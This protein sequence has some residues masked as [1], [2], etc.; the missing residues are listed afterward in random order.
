MLLSTF[1]F[2][3]I[4]LFFV[5]AFFT[6]TII[7]SF[8]NVY[9]YR[10]HTG[11]SLSGSSHCMSC[12]NNL[13]WYELVPLLSWIMLRG[14]CSSC[15]CNITPRYFLVELLTGVLFGLTLLI[16]L[17]VAEIIIMWYILST[18]VAITV[19][20]LYH[21]IIPDRLTAYLTG[22]SI[23]LFL[24]QNLF[25]NN[26][27]DNALPT[28]A[29]AALGSLFFYILWFVSR[30]RWLGFGDVKLALPLG[31]LVGPGLVFS[32]VVLAFWV[33]AGISILLIIANNFFGGKN[34]LHIKSKALTMKSEVPFA[35]FLIA[36]SL[37]IIFTN[38]NV[39]DL[40][41]FT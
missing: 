33:G 8:L 26:S 7:G 4:E 9:I 10:F 3:P 21:F 28:L 34:R 15:G 38:F 16:T 37:I 35:P 24:Y 27:L 13:K 19:Y 36:S 1:S 11:K 30:G 31:I 14:R 39:L 12:G 2:V 40:F 20:D 17:D 5:Y 6:G 32:F 18:L 29:A 22:S 25:L 41:S 23:I